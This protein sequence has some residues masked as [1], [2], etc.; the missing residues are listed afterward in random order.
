[1]NARILELINNPEI[2]QNQDLDLLNGELKKHPYLQNIRAI[3]LLGT[4]KF[5]SENYQKELS[6]TAAYTT[7]KKILYQFIN[8]K[9]PLNPFIEEVEKEPAE[10]EFQEELSVPKPYNEVT[11][12]EKPTAKPVFVE[13]NLNRILFEGEEDFLERENDTID[14][15]S[16]IE[17]GKIVTENL[18]ISKENIPDQIEEPALT[19]TEDAENFAPE[20]VVNEPVISVEE[21]A[22]EDLSTISFHGSEE[23]LPDVQIKTTNF[24]E[25]YTAPE[26]QWSKQELE[27]QRLIADVEAKMKASKKEKVSETEPIHNHDLNFS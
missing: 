3:H 13:G 25:K 5:E 6:V 9:T 20:T 27:M 24:E 18:S 19:E 14:I 12:V 10:P 11:I 2:I 26:P 1:M 23:F 17:S 22:I 21:P 16:T 8:K 4:H 7:D 15:Q